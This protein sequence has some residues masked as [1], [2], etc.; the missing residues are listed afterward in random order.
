MPYLRKRV[1]NCIVA[2]RLGIQNRSRPKNLLLS[3][4]EE[5]SRKPKQKKLYSTWSEEI[6]EIILFAV[7]VF[8]VLGT[9]LAFLIRSL[10]KMFKDIETIDDN[11]TSEE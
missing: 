11:Y 4:P 9:I 1:F 3:L 7:P 8:G 10:Y 6:M 5:I 2:N